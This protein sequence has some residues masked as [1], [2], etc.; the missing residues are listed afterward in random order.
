MNYVEFIAGNN[1]YKLRLTTKAVVALEKKLG[2]NPLGIFGSGDTIPT[3][4]TMI[5]I[6]HASLQALHH[7]INLDAAYDIWDEWINDGH[8]MTDFLTVILDIYRH[9]GLIG[10]A[11]EAT[12][13]N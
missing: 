11:E 12:E 2:C 8:T 6:L 3:V 9:S 5:T 13:K 4:T 7:G 1:T 10:E